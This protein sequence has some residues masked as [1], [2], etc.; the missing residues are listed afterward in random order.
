MG[1]ALLTLLAPFVGCSLGALIMSLVTLIVARTSG[2]FVFATISVVSTLVALALA[3][4][5]DRYTE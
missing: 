2:A 1:R 4:L 5:V 3:A